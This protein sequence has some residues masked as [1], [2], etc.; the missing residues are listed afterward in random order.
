[1]DFLLEQKEKD[2]WLQGTS[3]EGMTYADISELAKRGLGRCEDECLSRR[4]CGEDACACV[5]SVFPTPE[6]YEVYLN[7]RA[8]YLKALGQ[9]AFAALMSE[10]IQ[11]KDDE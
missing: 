2:D 1:M 6:H 7:A 5:R 8:F 10:G 9:A 11:G 3:E 4:V